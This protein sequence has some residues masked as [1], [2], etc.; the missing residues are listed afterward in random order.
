MFL[1]S[2]QTNPG[3][4]PPLPQKTP[5]HIPPQFA[6]PTLRFY[7]ARLQKRRGRRLAFP[8][9]YNPAGKIGICTPGSLQIF[10]PMRRGATGFRLLLLPRRR[11]GLRLLECLVSYFGC[12]TVGCWTVGRWTVGQ[13][14]LDLIC[15]KLKIIHLLD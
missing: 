7:P 5:R 8:G 10:C 14:T 12:W 1:R 13:W 3:P 6:D 2:N 4:P 9:Q 15:R 11:D